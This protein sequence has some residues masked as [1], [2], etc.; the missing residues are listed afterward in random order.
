M[1]SSI[2][3]ARRF[4]VRGVFWRQY[5][6][7]ATVN[8]PFYLYPVLHFFMT[9]FFFFFAA[10][11]RRIVLAHLAIILPGS[12]RMMNYL[13]VF[14]TF[15]NYSWT[16]SEAAIH[17][18]NKEEFAYEII[19][20]D[21]LDRLGAAQG[22]IVL[23]AHMGNYDLG[24]ALFAEKFNREIRLVRAPEPDEQTAEH[25]SAS[26][27]KSGEGAVKV[28]YNTGG[29]LLSF[30]LLNAL[31][32]GEI[33]SIQGDRI[34]AGLAEISAQLFGKEIRLP[35]GPFVLAQVSRAPIYPLFIARSG[36]R[37][38]QI[39]VSEPITVLRTGRDR[40]DDLAQAVEKWS[41]VLE[42]VIA[43][44]WDQWFAFAPGFLSE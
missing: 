11:A 21:W 19:G 33:V 9:L 17:K 34:E 3:W 31:R 2:N 28:D 30:D 18:L 37:S 7:W 43:E 6:D 24:A 29:A 26:L 13:R 12:S 1:N 22:A 41:G 23:T 5:L 32:L 20:A 4:A 15:H 44:R 39:I 38:Y 8:I 35:N 14:R 27:E 10:P 40:A 16:I 36:Y 42:Q 25:L